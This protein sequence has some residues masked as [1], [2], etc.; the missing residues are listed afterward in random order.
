MNAS[1][2]PFSASK[3]LLKLRTVALT[4]LAVL[5]LAL[6]WF[7]YSRSQQSAILIQGSFS[8]IQLTLNGRSV[9]GT[10]TSAGINLPVVAGS[11]RLEVIRSGYASYAQDVR[12]AVGE[13]ATIRPLFTL[14]PSSTS[15]AT[16]DLHFVRPV[17]SQNLVFYLGDA[18]TRLYR[19]DTRAK[20]ITAVSERSLSNITDVQWPTRSDVALIT[21]GDGVYLLEVPKFDFRTQHFERVAGTEYVSPVWE[22]GAERIA[23]ALITPGGERSLVLTDKRFQTV[24]RVADLTGFTNPKVSWS[25][26]GK[27]LLV[28]NQAPDSS[29]DNVWVYSLV[30]ATFQP[31]TSEG[32]VTGARMNPADDTVLLARGEKLSFRAL[33]DPNE[34][35]IQ[36]NADI[37]R[38][39]WSPSGKLYLSTPS[40]ELFRIGTDG[41]AANVPFSLEPQG[42]VE[43]LFAFD[44]PAALIF[45]TE[46]AVYS[47]DLGG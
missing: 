37:Q 30:R 17:P 31:I 36:Q 12:V 1:S 32:G 5:L 40:G 6:G 7:W 33:S 44:D 45:Y 13:T 21:R 9:T 41:T 18:G 26:G 15:E 8:D 22:P 10:A 47:V 14:L 43:G 16:G 4:A 39:A 28:R 27:Y 20:E 25:P 11:Y 2:D 42:T 34:Q 29:Q 3:R 46:Q 23:A 19:Y 35:A 24:R 38:A